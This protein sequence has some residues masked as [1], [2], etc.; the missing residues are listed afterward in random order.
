MLAAELG[1]IPSEASRELVQ[2]ILTAIDSTSDELRNLEIR[3]V[4]TLASLRSVAAAQARRQAV[5]KGLASL[6]YQV[7]EGMETAWVK[8]GRLVLKKTSQPGYGVELGGKGE[9][10]RLQ[11]RTVAFRNQTTAGDLPRDRDAETIWCTE[12]TRL[13]EQFAASG[14]GIIIERAVPA[15]V[16]PLKL[17]EES[18]IVSTDTETEAPRAAHRRTIK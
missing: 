1:Q 14:G 12:L 2:R 6:G 3:A 11:I 9:S 7:N 10:D 8:E 18:P 5:L 17:V 16:T 13:E 4:A 15:G